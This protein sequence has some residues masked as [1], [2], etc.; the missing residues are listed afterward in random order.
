MEISKIKVKYNG[1]KY[2]SMQITDI[3]VTYVSSVTVNDEYLIDETEFETEDE[4]IEYV[5]DY[6]NVSA[7]I[8]EVNSNED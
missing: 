2:M 5:A 7:D 3:N 1:P 4:L 6:Y 8:I